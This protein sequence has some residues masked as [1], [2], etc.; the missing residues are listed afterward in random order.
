[1]PSDI[2]TAVRW[3]KK[4][5]AVLKTRFGATGRGLHE[6]VSS[7]ESKLDAQTVRDLRFV[8]TI[9]NKLL[10]DDTYDRIDDRRAFRAKA[11]RAAKSLGVRKGRRRILIVFGVVFTAVLATAILALR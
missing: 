4:L 1:M 5:E 7:V 11:R 8:A 3:S 6:K 9:R 2:D 10:H